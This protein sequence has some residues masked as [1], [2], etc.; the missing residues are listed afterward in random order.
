MK[1]YQGN[2]ARGIAKDAHYTVT[3]D[4]KVR[5]T[6]SIGGNEK[7]LL[8]TDAHPK[9]VSIVN[10]AKREGRNSQGGGRFAINEFRHVLV[11]LPSGREVI[12]AGDYER[13]LEFK[14]D[15]TTVISPIAPKNL[16]PG[17]I[18]RGPHVGINYTL[19][20]G[21]ANIRFTTTTVS[22]E[23]TKETT[24][25]LTDFHSGESLA[26]LLQMCRAVKPNGGAIYINEARELFAPVDNKKGKYERLYIGN[27]GNNPWFPS[28]ITE[29]IRI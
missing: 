24:I 12:Y 11:P 27:L 8:T 18:W 19:A 25:A 20:A 23:R 22:G 29:D 1:V 10:A 5:L 13:N 14:F 9:L 3:S 4:G 28:S 16:R 26:E 2:T 7:Y 21:A 6:Y 17:D 15:E